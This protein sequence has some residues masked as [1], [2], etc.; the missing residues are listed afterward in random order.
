MTL[1]QLIHFVTVAKAGSFSGA[2]RI[3]E[4]AQSAVS[5]S[6]AALERDL[7]AKLLDRTSRTCRVTPLGEQ[8]LVDAQRIVRDAEDTR[9]RIRR[10]GRAGEG[11]LVLGL[12]GGLSGL[13]TER[14]LGYVMTQA[15][16]LDIAIV[17]GSVGRLRELLLEQRIDCA[18]TYEVAQD[19]PQLRGRFIAFEPMHLVAHPEVASRLLKPGPIDLAQIARFPLFLPSLL[20]EDGAGRLLA[21]EAAKHH[22]TLDIRYELQSTSLMRRLLVQDKLAT[23]IGIG[24]IV[25]EVASGE[26]TARVVELPAFTRAVF[27]ATQ[28][29][30]QPGPAEARLLQAVQQIAAD[31]LLPCGL[32]RTARG[33]F[34]R[35]D[36]ELFRRLR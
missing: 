29:S 35:P 4:V 2:A 6:I 7:D 19:D 11:H 36:Y 26:L 17:E 30:R 16:G 27:L 13:L 14:L 9:D 34:T 8:F 25:D 33:Q 20:R 23:V 3:L 12:T 21:H 24:S 28:A 10:A 15:P 5:Q 22:V 1:V 31:F 18:I 32:W